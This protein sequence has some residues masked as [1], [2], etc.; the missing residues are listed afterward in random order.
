MGYIFF[1]KMKI[2]KQYGLISVKECVCV[3]AHARVKMAG[4]MCPKKVSRRYSWV[5]EL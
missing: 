1:L 4:N 5:I 3:R 2:V